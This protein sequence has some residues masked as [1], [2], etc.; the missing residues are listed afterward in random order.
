V[1]RRGGVLQSG[2][3]T[4][5]FVKSVSHPVNSRAAIIKLVVFIDEFLVLCFVNAANGDQWLR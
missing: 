1:V 5:D 4:G 2:I 3:P